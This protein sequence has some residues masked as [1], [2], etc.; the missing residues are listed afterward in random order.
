MWVN[1]SEGST[2]RKRRAEGASQRRKQEH[3][4]P[5]VWHWSIYLNVLNL[6]DCF[7]VATFWTMFWF[8]LIWNQIQRLEKKRILFISHL[9]LP[10]NVIIS[11]IISIIFNNSWRHFTLKMSGFLYQCKLRSDQFII[12]CVSDRSILQMWTSW[13]IRCSSSL[14]MIYL[15]VLCWWIKLVF[16][17]G[18]LGLMWAGTWFVSELLLVSFLCGRELNVEARIRRRPGGT[19]TRPAREAEGHSV[20]LFWKYKFN[21]I[22]ET[23]SLCLRLE[24]VR[25]QR[26]VKGELRLNFLLIKDKKSLIDHRAAVV[27]SLLLSSEQFDLSE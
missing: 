26:S 12:S 5:A 13:R 6:I 18:G 17:L 15:P 25:G 9:Q 24:P 4:P 16:K 14:F 21:K 1:K 2:E 8:H 3:Q 27:I 10:V 11:I 7:C 22:N 23:F 19:N 20:L